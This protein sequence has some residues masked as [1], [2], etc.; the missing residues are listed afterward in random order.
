M[1]MQV[2]LTRDHLCIVLEY[3]SAGELFESVRDA[4]RFDEDMA[5]FFFQQL[6]AG[7]LR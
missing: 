6:I 5:R 3:A 4:G 1:W 2:F 7:T